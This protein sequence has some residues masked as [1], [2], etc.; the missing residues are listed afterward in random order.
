MPTTN[1]SSLDSHAHDATLRS[2][3]VMRGTVSFARSLIQFL[4]RTAP[5]AVFFAVALSS[6]AR[7]AECLSVAGQLNGKRVAVTRSVWLK[8]GK[9]TLSGSMNGVKSP[10]RQLPCKTLAKGVY[11]DGMF[12]GVL[13]SV[14][15]N[16]RRMIETITDPQTGKEIASFAYKCDRAMKP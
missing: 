8:P 3:V 5:V 12:D 2:Q 9:I 4:S 10:R 6:H 16:G 15:T 1:K 7:A 14:V 13:V 11:C